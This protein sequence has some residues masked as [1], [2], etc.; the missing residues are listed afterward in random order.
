M[1]KNIGTKSARFYLSVYEENN[2]H[3]DSSVT[4]AGFF[5]VGIY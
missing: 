3:L 4:K 1:T 5:N 2:H